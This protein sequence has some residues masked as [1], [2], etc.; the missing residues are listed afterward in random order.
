MVEV[1]G[2]QL[3]KPTGEGARRLV[4]HAAKH[5][6]GQSIELRMHGREQVRMRV[7]MYGGPPAGHTVDEPATVGQLNACP[8]G[9]NNGGRQGRGLVLGIGLPHVSMTV[10]QP[11]GQRPIDQRFHAVGDAAGV[12]AA[13]GAGWAG[14]LCGSGCRPS[15]ANSAASR[16]PGL[17]V[18]RSFSPQKIE[19]APA[20]K[21][22][23]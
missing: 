6:V 16:L 23:A 13:S 10:V 22:R 7:A 5:H 11:P 9:P 19:L 17:S 20:K 8:A 15:L 2:E 14:Q 3:R 18:V 12:A 1:A 4:G 21:H